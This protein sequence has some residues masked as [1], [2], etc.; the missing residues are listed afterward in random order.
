MESRAGHPYEWR[1]EAMASDL[2]DGITPALVARFRK[3]MLGL[4][5]EPGLVQEVHRRLTRVYAL[6]TP[7][8]GASVNLYYG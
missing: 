8:L 4:R 5:R 2:A 7:G 3:A 1:A 6:V